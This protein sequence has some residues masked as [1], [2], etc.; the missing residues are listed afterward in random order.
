[1]AIRFPNPGEKVKF[2]D[3]DAVV[4]GT[5]NGEPVSL[6]DGVEFSHLPVYVH[7]TDKCVMVYAKNIIEW[8]EQG[9]A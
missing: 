9:V 8:P 7:E 6:V 2:Q 1:M 5:C 3:G 4:E